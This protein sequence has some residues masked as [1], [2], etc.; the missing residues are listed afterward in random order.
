MIRVLIAEDMHMIRG[1]LTALLS[2]ES[3]VEV[4]A[5]LDRGDQIVE[6]ALQT[7]PDVA[8]LDIDLPGLDGLSAAADLHR[9]VPD[10]R[11]LILTGLTQPGNLLRA[12]QAHVRGFIVKDA[13]AQTLADGI[14]RVAAGERVIDPDLI[15]GAL[16]TGASPLTARETDVLRTAGSGNSTD[17]IARELSLSPA[18]VRNYLS[19]AI[20]KV[21]RAQP[22]R[23]DPDRPR[24]RVAI[25]RAAPAPLA[26]SA[27][28]PGEQDRGQNLISI[29]VPGPPRRRGRPSAVTRRNTRNPQPYFLRNARRS[30]RRSRPVTIRAVPERQ[31][32]RGCPSNVDGATSTLGSRAIRRALP[33]RSGVNPTHRA[34]SSASQTGVST[35]DPSARKV[36]RAK[37]RSPSGSARRATSALQPARDR[38]R[39]ALRVV[40]VARCTGGSACR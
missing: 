23:R 35:G 38:R 27:S 4:V 21:G 13:P 3:D 17:E 24:R 37:K 28:R 40:A 7:R 20:S 6:A 29:P 26:A 31:A 33:E 30:A 8:I 11:V 2:L 10:C 15:A 22:H 19:N 9:E 16:E 32:P 39:G 34:P 12:L 5:E 1:A 18:T 36:R 14:R 25:T